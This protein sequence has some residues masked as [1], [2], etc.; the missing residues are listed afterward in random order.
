M[1]DEILLRKIRQQVDEAKPKTTSKEMKLSRDEA[2]LEAE[3][4]FKKGILMGESLENIF[5][6]I[7]GYLRKA[8]YDD[9]RPPE[10]LKFLFRELGI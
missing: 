3:Y 1:L 4:L 7:Y 2:L 5:Y 6:I 10:L 8:G 9:I